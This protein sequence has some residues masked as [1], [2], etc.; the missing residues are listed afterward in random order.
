MSGRP[1]FPTTAVVLAGGRASRLGRDK[2]LEE[3]GGSPLLARVVAAVSVISGDIVIVGD[4][5]ASRRAVTLPV[6]GVR[7]T[8]DRYGGERGPLAGLHAGLSEA[9]HDLVVAVA[10][11]MPFL[12]PLVLA[13]LVQAAGRGA[14]EAVVPRIDGRPQPLH[15]VYRKEPV[16]ERAAELLEESD[17]APGIQDLLRRLRAEYVDQEQIALLDSELRSFRSVDT[18]VDLAEARRLAGGAG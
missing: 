5:D 4:N 18:E 9:T 8:Q 2:A 1:E 10:C 14:N 15:S 12:N 7:W 16:G 17:R 3:V 11:D 13:S 6:A